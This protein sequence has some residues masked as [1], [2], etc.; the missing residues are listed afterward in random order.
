MK[1]FTRPDGTVKVVELKCNACGTTFWE[2]EKLAMS[3]KTHFCNIVCYSMVKRNPKGK[4]HR[5]YGYAEL[6][7]N[8]AKRETDSVYQTAARFFKQ[9]KDF[10][11]EANEYSCIPTYMPELEELVN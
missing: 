6:I 4:K 10:L 3:K 5:D 8:A 11:Y 1:Y 7:A 2:S 9:R